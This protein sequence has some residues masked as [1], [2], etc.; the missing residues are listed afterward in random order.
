MFTT[1][2]RTEK[3]LD[4]MGVK[5]RYTNDLTFGA[6]APSW[7]ATNLGRSQVKVEKAIQEYGLLMD[8]GS[9]APAPILW[10]DPSTKRHEVLDGMQRLHTEQRRNPSTFSAYVVETDSAV[11]VKKIRVF[12]NYRLQGGYQESAEWTLE[13][14]V[15]L[16]VG[17]GR[18]SV[19]E[20]AE[21]GGWTVSSVRDKKEC[22]DW[23]FRIRTIGGPEKFPDSVIRVIAKSAQLEDL[24]AAAAPVAEFLIDV[25]RMRLSAEEA[26]P[27]VEEFFSVVRRKGKLHEQ[28][29][30]KLEEFHADDEVTIRLADPARR[31]YQ[32]MTAE[33]RLLRALKAAL[34]TAERVQSGG[35]RIPFMAEY[36]QV[37]G[38]IEKVLKQIESSSRK[39][40]HEQQ[41]GS[42]R[43]PV[44]A[45]KLLGSRQARN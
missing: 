15:F 43:I 16:L 3:F 37:L 17:E 32:P 8:R 29:A 33:S 26:T 44:E 2:S 31:R 6:L 4:W 5:W 18:M 12:A 41:K 21:M 24:E 27:Y 42:S 38:R 30:E 39:Q 28:F 7:E 20:V 34:T 9:P 45:E 13:R 1:D 23:G 14:A 10:N 19:E 22:M 35:D 40:K 36:F 25:K 11:M